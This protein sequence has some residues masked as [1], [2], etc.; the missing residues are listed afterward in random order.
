MSVQV[1][2][3]INRIDKSNRGDMMA[4]PLMYYFE[5]FKHYNL[6]R[7][8][9]RYIDFN[10]INECDVVIIGGGGVIDFNELLNRNIN[11]ILNTGATCILWAG[12]INTHYDYCRP[13]RTKIDFEKFYLATLRD[14]QNPY[15]LEYLPDVSCKIQLLSAKYEI[16]REIGVA[17][18]KDFNI[19]VDEYSQI[20]NSAGIDEIIK[21]IGES[22]LIISNSFHLLYWSLLMGKKVLCAN[23]FSVKFSFFKYNPYI[24]DLQNESLDNARNN[25]RKYD[26]LAECIDMNDAFFNRVKEFVE[27]N[28]K[29]REYPYTYDDISLLESVAISYSR[30]REQVL[31]EGDCFVSQ[32][33]VDRGKGF[34]ELEKYLF[35]GNILGD[36]VYHAEFLV[37]M[38]DVKALRFDPIESHLC[39]TTIIESKVDGTNILFSPLYSVNNGKYDRFLTTDP[40]YLAVVFDNSVSERVRISICFELRLYSMYENEYSLKTLLDESNQIHIKADSLNHEIDSLKRHIKKKNREMWRKR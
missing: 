38:T 39:D 14:Y 7:H 20:N 11:R 21:F 3:F 18:H 29:K 36:S 34:N 28:V 13:F 1:I 30:Q 9:I 8:D 5:F 15:G 23:P 4:C 35:V 26:C 16:V 32:L 6:R 17:M 22:E 25:A 31:T 27:H 37:D 24:W 40:N 19:P 33:Y 10:S 12:G 2:H